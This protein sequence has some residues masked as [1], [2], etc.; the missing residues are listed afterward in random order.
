MNQAPRTVPGS[1]SAKRFR[2]GLVVGKFSPLHRGHELVIERALADCDEVLIISYSVPEF[3]RC[4]ATARE[5][6]LAELFPQTRRLVIDAAGLALRCAERG[7]TPRDIPHNDVGD[8]P[9][10]RFCA[11][12]CHGILDFH[13]DAI[14]TSE[15]YGD[16]FAAAMGESLSAATGSPRT[17]NH[18]CVDLQ[19]SI[20]PVS[21]TM[22]RAN[23]HAK[24][25][26]MSP[27]VY[28]DFVERICL[29]GAESA[30]KTTL[31][32]ALAIAHGTAWVPEYGRERWIE[33]DG[34]LDFSDM[35]RIGQRQIALE[36]R[37]AQEASRWLFCDTS[38]LTT[39]FYSEAMFGRVDEQLR[40]LACRPYDRIW[41]C[42]PDFGFVQDGTRR[43]LAFR[44]RQHAWYLV[45]LDR[46]GLSYEVL[47]GSHDQR[48]ARAAALIEMTQPR[49]A[50]P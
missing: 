42:A 13:P 8:E 24:R 11:W 5:R 50:E 1:A 37:M 15:H 6:W 30:G 16:G 35:L 3:R 21:G 22:L 31:A 49:S 40:E 33:K 45:E 20:K 43:D 10:R 23:P 2:R 41:L 27:V 44:D 17:V 18:V 14:F 46:R 38:P 32:E 25:E 19:R 47:A 7:L 9:H 34:Q 29:L 28:A 39:V 36:R 12:L 48:M 26:C 4:P